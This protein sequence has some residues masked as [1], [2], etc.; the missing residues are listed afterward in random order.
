MVTALTNACV[1]HS[2]PLPVYQLSGFILSL[3]T[4]PGI[5]GPPTPGLRRERPGKLRACAVRRGVGTTV[6][7]C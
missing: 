1:A 2:H 3:R 7:L 4:S 5:G 6:A